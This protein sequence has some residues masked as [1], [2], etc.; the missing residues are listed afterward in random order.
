MSWTSKFHKQPKQQCYRLQSFFTHVIKTSIPQHLER[1]KIHIK[2]YIILRHGAHLFPPPTKWDRASVSQS[3]VLTGRCC[4]CRWRM[5]RSRRTYFCFFC[6]FVVLLLLFV[7]VIF[8]V[9]LQQ[10]GGQHRPCCFSTTAA[11]PVSQP[12]V[13]NRSVRSERKVKPQKDLKQHHVVDSFSL[14]CEHWPIQM[15]KEAYMPIYR[16]KLSLRND[17]QEKERVRDLPGLRLAKI[18]YKAYRLLL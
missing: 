8:A 4:H 2:H 1:E 16:P 12:R 7:V 13:Q 14:E 18:K 11:V 17:Q 15:P 5:T 9:F 3:L 10:A 6:G